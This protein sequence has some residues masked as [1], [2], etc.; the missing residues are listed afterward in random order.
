M[1]FILFIF[2][3][4]NILYATTSPSRT[5]TMNDGPSSV[6]S[7]TSRFHDKSEL[8]IIIVAAV[9]LVIL[10]A[11]QFVYTRSLM[12]KELEKSAF[13]EL[14]SSALRIQEVLSSAE[15]SVSNQIWHAEEHLGDPDYMYKLV[16]NLVKDDSD[17]IIGSFVCFKPDF[18]PKKG[19]LYEPYARQWS[20]DSITVRQIASRQSHDYT[21]STFYK[22]AMLGDTTDWSLPYPDAE[23][24]QDFVT[25]YAMPIMNNNG[26]PV[27]ALGVDLRTDWIADVVNLNHIHPSSFSLVISENGELIASPHD[28]VAS[29]ELV[30]Y[31]V[32]LFNDST[33]KRELKAHGRI[34]KIGF[35]DKTKREYG[36]IYYARKE[37]KPHWYMTVVCYNK[38]VFSQLRTMEWNI[39]LLGLIAM[40]I[41][42]YIVHLFAKSNRR[43]IDTGMERERL[44]SELRV[45]KEIQMNML[46]HENAVR[47]EDISVYG[48]LMPAREVGGDLYDF[49]VRDE[50]LFFCI[51]DV[52]GKGV[53]AAMMMSQTLS[54]LRSKAANEN[55]PARILNSVNEVVCNGNDANMFV[56]LFIG[57][58][59]LPTGKLRYCNAGHNAPLLLDGETAAPC[60]TKPNLPV[61]V[62]ADV[63]YTMYEY[64]IPPHSLLFLYTDGL[65]EARNVRHEMFGTERLLLADCG[66]HVMPKEY[67][68]RMM[69]SVQEFAQ[70]ES[71]SDDLT[72]L[73]I[74][75]NPKE[76]ND[77]LCES[78][79]ISNNLQQVNLVSAF[80]KNIASQLEI[81][82]KTT[83]E[84]R[85]AVEEAV[86]NIIHYAYPS[87]STGNIITLEAKSDGVTLM[88][89][90]TDSG[91]AFDPTEV[92]DADTTM[93]AE[94]RP[95]GGLGI[96]LIRQLTD[97]INYKRENGKNILTM[98]KNITNKI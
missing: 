12:E 79:T 63:R 85:L 21:K 20:V 86:V 66:L 28:S 88:L 44:N 37:N 24:A 15:V 19:E 73:A 34:T 72:M 41:L 68:E 35:Y 48:T 45:A 87:G 71:Q 18:F 32:T 92:P 47:R 83:G 17:D 46:P 69:Q 22:N 11:V 1:S 65:T 5:Y 61:G 95:I 42:G 56:T 59:D 33:V 80:I 97:S 52:S 36:S 98:R 43:L 84:I 39:L 13:R 14:I 2:A 89:I 30:N 4:I 76:E 81:D 16:Y 54:L 26:E 55:N 29:P 78:L 82:K 25:T 93:S 74:K 51:G 40:A 6:E 53:P 91:A 77:I 3:A 57:V 64:T 49:F 58:L 27:G 23:G 90:L 67:I 50:K 9:M 8:V 60:D 38:Q 96:H 70:G 10:S 62:F 7:H 31:I 75:Y 94:E